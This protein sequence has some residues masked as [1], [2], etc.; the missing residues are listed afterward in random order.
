METRRGRSSKIVDRTLKETFSEKSDINSNNKLYKTTKTEKSPKEENDVPYDKVNSEHSSEDEAYET[1]GTENTHE[2]EMDSFNEEFNGEN[3]EEFDTFNDELNGENSRDDKQDNEV[4]VKIQ[5]NNATGENRC[6]HCKEIFENPLLL[7]RHK[8]EAHKFPK[9]LLPRE[10]IE[11]YYDYPNRS[12]CPICKKVI[13]TN[14][15]RSIYL[16]HLHTHT[17]IAVFECIICKKVFKR[18]DHMV[19]HQKRHIVPI[20]DFIKKGKS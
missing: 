18:K 15:F 19:N 1:T 10:E 5:F 12:F 20:E 8:R 13:K 17:V 16:K 4:K 14:N 6:N 11:K 3:E 9:K 2:E 7:L